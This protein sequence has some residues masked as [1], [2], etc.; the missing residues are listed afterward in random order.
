MTTHFVS[1]I[2][3]EIAHAVGKLR[4]ISSAVVEAKDRQMHTETDRITAANNYYSRMN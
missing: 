3:P 2:I 4:I 1:I